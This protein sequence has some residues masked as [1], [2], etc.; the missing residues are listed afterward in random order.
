MII[1][2]KPGT[3]QADID[4]VMDKVREHSLKPVSFEG[5]EQTVIHVIGD[6]RDETPIHFQGIPCVEKIVRIQK[7]YKLA[8]REHTVQKTVIKI[9]DV[10]IGDGS[11]T[12]IAGPD[13]VETEH[14]IIKSA[15]LMKEAGIKIMRA[16]A[17]KPRTSPYSFQGLGI[18]G[19]KLLKK[20]RD[21]VGILVETEVMDVRDVPVA[22]QYVDILRVGARN[23]QNFDLLKELGKIDK[24]V[25]LKRGMSATLNEFLMAAEYILSEGNRH[26]ILCERGIRT[27]ETAY[28]NTLDLLGVVVLQQETHLP[29][30]VDPSHTSGKREWVKPLCR[31]AA[32]VG[33]D[34]LILEVHP[35]PEKA[36]CD[37]QQSLTPDQLKEMLQEIRPICASLGK[38]L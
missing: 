32:A 24:P 26:V 38:T 19:L 35:E 17:F 28:R 13:S 3:Q 11:F 27:F 37:G 31:A 23:M 30:I 4:A 36:L 12:V 21:E 15:Q 6:V 9:G 10:S 7:P 14:Q 25:I 18:D 20:A 29:I 2:L 16:S 33:A 8:S 34:G 22:A 1:V 5:V